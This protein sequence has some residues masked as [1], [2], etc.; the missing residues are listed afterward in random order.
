MCIYD[1][2]FIKIKKIKKNIYFLIVLV[3]KIF[4]DIGY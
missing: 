3:Y 4:I 2:F 1:K